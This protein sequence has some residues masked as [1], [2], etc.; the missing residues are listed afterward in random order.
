MNHVGL[1]LHKSYSYVVI[2]D[3][4]GTLIDQRRLTNEAVASI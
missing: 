1:D 3:D 4:V 2:L